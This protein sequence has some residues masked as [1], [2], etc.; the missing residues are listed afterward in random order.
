MSYRINIETWQRYNAE[1][2]IATALPEAQ[3]QRFEQALEEALESRA[4]AGGPE[5][6][7]ADGERVF[8]VE[9][10]DSLAEIADELNVDFDELLELNRRDDMPNPSRID[11]GDV[12]FVPLIAPEEAA[13]SPRNAQGVP[14]G[15][16][17]FV[18]SLREQ[19]NA[20]EYADDPSMVDYAAETDQLTSDIQAYVE[21]LPPSERQAGLQRLYD[22]D[23][24]DAGPAQMAIER[25]AEEMGV[26]LE[27]TSHAGPE[28]EEQARKIIANAQAES[29]P[30]RVLRILEEGYDSASPAVQAALDRSDDARAIAENT[31]DFLDEAQTAEDPAEA[32]RIYQEGY[33]NAPE[34]VQNALDLSRDA[35]AI[36]DD[37][38]AWAAEPLE[39]ELDG[40]ETPQ[41]RMLIA[42][43]RLDTLTEGRGPRST[44]EV[45]DAMLPHFDAA[46]T[47]FQEYGGLIV[48]PS[49]TQQLIPILDRIDGT[50]TGDA[51]IQRLVELLRVDMN[52]LRGALNDS[53]SEG[54]RIPALA[55]E[56]AAQE[57]ASGFR[58]EVFAAVENFRDYGIE[59][60]AQ[61]YHSHLEEL[62]YMIDAGGA[63]MTPDQLEAAIDDYIESQDDGWGEELE[64]LR[65]DLAAG[66][67]GLLEQVQQLQSLPDDI[68]ADYQ[69][70][71]GGLLDDTNAQLAVS[72][73]LQEKGEL[74]RGDAGETLIEVFNELGISGDDPLAATLVG[75]YL[76]ENVLGSVAELDFTD[77]SAMEEARDA[78]GEALSDQPQL[79]ELMGVST[80]KL[81][82]LATLLSGV[83]PGEPLSGGNE[84]GR[85]NGILRNLN[86]TLDQI[87]GKFV[88]NT[89]FRT[90]FRTTA[91]TI[92]G[93]GLINAGHNFL[94][95]PDLRNSAELGVALSRVGVDSAQLAAAVRS[96]TNTNTVNGL[97]TAGKFVH[98]MGATLAGL[99]AVSRLR[100]GDYLGAGL[101]TAVAG[102][103]G[104]A[105]MFSSTSW[106]GPVGFGIATA[107][108]VGLYIQE[109][110]KET[111]YE[112]PAMADFLTHAGFSEAAA[113]ILIERS[114]DGYNAV[115]LLM[116]YGELHGLDRAQTV[117]W[118]NAI[119][120]KENGSAMLA[121]LRDNLH[122]TLDNR[123]ENGNI[124][125]FDEHAEGFELFSP[126]L[127]E[128][129]SGVL[130]PRSAFEL[131][132]I[133]PQLGIASPEAYA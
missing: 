105:V 99:D 43:Q 75:A 40:V 81:D 129:R 85:V 18:R 34:R 123:L 53:V 73:A 47:R 120:R 62:G 4:G 92:V 87:D 118:I 3:R 76:N 102:G 33:D 29:D 5:E 57:G 108:S 113:E 49:G 39:G 130:E 96:I 93:S 58:E 65:G 78:I 50:D 128:A 24:V 79:A 45:M 127:G 32:L 111:P 64:S 44:A 38:T 63:S 89:P 131:D 72:T 97:K 114:D 10:G 98:I 77:A 91:V 23:W 11:S 70:R 101:N 82:E 20:L 61:A 28:I 68:R 133:L 69:D 109:S 51:T 25:T 2:M 104:M 124:H 116:R 106:G 103:V 100:D 80:G 35:Q 94:E 67:A 132:A 112:T 107:A 66:G 56:L 121:A 14:D 31:A 110:L 125:Q 60:N 22:H 36:I 12:V 17:G 54:G 88:R 8:I 7:D 84:F 41:Q 74:V 42:S 1:G 13:M 115:P 27:S 37:A 119:P 15:E 83:L 48:G 90:A 71:I 19:G 6:F 52:S 21:A 9:E 126:S 46:S 117:K 16:A 55:L 122:N 59:E 95:N 30:D 86:N 26:G